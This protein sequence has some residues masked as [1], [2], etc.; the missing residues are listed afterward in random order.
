MLGAERLHHAAVIVTDLERAK[1]FYGRVL[2]LEEIK[3]PNF[4]FGGAWYAVGDDQIH[5]IVHSEALAV[6]GSTSIDTRDAHIALRVENYDQALEHLKKQGVEVVANADSITGWG[7][8]FFC[9]P[10]GNVIEL[11]APRS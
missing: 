5:L 11:N 7:Q 9:D 4:S 8:I 3:R 10:D 1:D 6:R 2:G